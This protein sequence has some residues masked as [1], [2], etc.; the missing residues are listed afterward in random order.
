MALRTRP[1]VRMGDSAVLV[2]VADV[3]AFVCEAGLYPS[4]VVGLRE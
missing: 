2:L 4:I 1:N 3:L